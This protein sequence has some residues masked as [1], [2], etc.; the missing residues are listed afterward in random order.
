MRISYAWESYAIDVNC[1]HATEKGGW[2]WGGG[3]GSVRACVCDGGI[4]FLFL[5]CKYSCFY[6]TFDL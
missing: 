3:G 6:R 5:V 1:I 2:G 4:I